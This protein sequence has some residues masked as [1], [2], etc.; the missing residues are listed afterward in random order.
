MYRHQHA[1]SL[2]PLFYGLCVCIHKATYIHTR[3]ST[4]YILMYT[5]WPL[6]QSA[7]ITSLNKHNPIVMAYGDLLV[8]PRTIYR[9]IHGLEGFVRQQLTDCACSSE[10]H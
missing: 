3:T 5:T 1:L 2:H 7:L 8:E 10:W 4:L 6:P 9:Y